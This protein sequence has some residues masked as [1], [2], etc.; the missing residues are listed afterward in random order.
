MLTKIFLIIASTVLLLL[1]LGLA[2]ANKQQLALALFGL[3]L[4][5]QMW[6]FLWI[7]L[8]FAIGFFYGAFYQGLSKAEL[9]KRLKQKTAQ[10]IELENRLESHSGTRAQS[11][12]DRADAL[13]S[14]Q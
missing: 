12:S 13:L 3:D 4:Q 6:V 2:L 7:I 9:N 1:G 11:L 14:A 8:F 10:V 5:V